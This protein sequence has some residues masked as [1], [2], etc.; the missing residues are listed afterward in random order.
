MHSGTIQCGTIS[1]AKQ[2]ISLATLQKLILDLPSPPVFT[3]R[4]CI[5]VAV[6]RAVAVKSDGILIQDE[7]RRHQDPILAGNQEELISWMKV[8]LRCLK[9]CN[10]LMFETYGGTAK[11][12]PPAASAVEA[13]INIGTFVCGGKVCPTPNV[14]TGGKVCP[15]VVVSAA[16]VAVHGWAMT[17]SDI[18]K[19]SLQD[20]SCGGLVRGI[21]DWRDSYQHVRW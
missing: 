11:R 7:L 2:L 13:T 6:E 19:V 17:V 10:A 5:H 12:Q 3:A 9:D 16:G 4:M 15:R 14:S 20:A 8:T 18:C 1:Y 21:G